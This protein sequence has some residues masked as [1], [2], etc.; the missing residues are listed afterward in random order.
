MEF[1][2]AEKGRKSLQLAERGA[3]AELRAVLLADLTELEAKDWAGDGLLA[4]ACWHGREETA[5]MLLT[6]FK[7]DVNARNLNGATP[8]H[9][10][11]QA[12]D[13]NCAQDLLEKSADAS[14][15]DKGGKKPIDVAASAEMKELIQGLLDITE[16]Y[17]CELQ[18]KIE[19][20]DREHDE[21]VELVSLTRFTATLCS[22]H[23]GITH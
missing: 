21:T 13:L 8:L 4:I 3:T 18:K 15:C 2:S 16:E 17:I 9:R 19:E 11:S 14:L 1:V 23:G 10:A 22:L 5:K 12:G 6:E 7:V 20:A